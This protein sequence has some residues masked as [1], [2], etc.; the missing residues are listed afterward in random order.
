MT[1]T[2][3]AAAYSIKQFLVAKQVLV[4]A[5]PFSLHLMAKQAGVAKK[6]VTHGDSS[7]GSSW[8]Q[9]ALLPPSSHTHAKPSSPGLSTQHCSFLLLHAQ[10]E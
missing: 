10:Q 8:E 7:C 1:Q 3:K 2:K 4:P 6:G 9:S 5:R